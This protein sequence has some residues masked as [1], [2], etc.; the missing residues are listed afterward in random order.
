M[1]SPPPE[2]VRVSKEHIEDS[3]ELGSDDSSKR[4]S[5]SSDEG[6]VRPVR[7]ELAET[8]MNQSANGK[9][10]TDSIA[11]D[12][13]ATSDAEVEKHGKDATDIK[14]QGRLRRKRSIE[15]VDE[16]LEDVKSKPGRHGRKRSRD[17]DEDSADGK[18]AGQDD[19]GPNAIGGVNASLTSTVE[20]NINGLNDQRAHTPEADDASMHSPTNLTSPKGK[21]N[22]AQF[23]QDN[24]YPSPQS[25]TAPKNIPA[26]ETNE[27]VL[28]DPKL[29]GEGERS[30]KRQRSGSPKPA[31]LRN[32]S[33]NPLE[34][35]PSLAGEDGTEKSIEQGSE[36]TAEDA[37][38]KSTTK[39]SEAAKD[40]TAKVLF[41]SSLDY[42]LMLTW[43]AASGIQC[44]WKSLRYV[45]IRCPVRKEVSITSP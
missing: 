6:G 3:M 37:S 19:I 20:Q 7:K 38:K 39:S 22:R 40:D 44:F 45:T 42:L 14:N 36:Q 29:T 23:L 12:N 10:H 21:R 41:I 9:D 34:K 32:A 15:D 4:N 33:E 31:S 27:T 18:P 2:D 17:G 11:H 35:I 5:I 26:T 43:F 30:P 1:A 16:R 13:A 8:S 25:M 24:E 28:E